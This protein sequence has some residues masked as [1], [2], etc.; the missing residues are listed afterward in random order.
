MPVELPL[1]GG[2][3]DRVYRLTIGAHGIDVAERQIGSLLPVR[4]ITSPVPHD[5]Y[6]HKVTDRA[7]FARVVEGARRAGADDGLMLT[8]EGYVAEASIWC[9]FWWEGDRLSAPALD[10]EILPGVSRMRLEEVAG[11][12]T[13][14]RVSRA[15]LEG[16]SLFVANAVRGVVPV[17]ALDGNP[18]LQHPRTESLQARFWP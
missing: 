18:M 17:A 1:P 5:P 16:K 10:L 4:L 12:L 13:E 6:A 9:L 7:Q 15:A 14:R 2:G 8:R 3:P 11:P